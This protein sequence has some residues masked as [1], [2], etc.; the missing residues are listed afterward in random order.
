M[1]KTAEKTDKKARNERQESILLKTVVQT[2]KQQSAKLIT[3]SK[4]LI[5]RGKRLATGTKAQ[6]LDFLRI[7]LDVGLTFARMALQSQGSSAKRRRNRA[8][9][10]KAYDSFAAWEKRLRLTAVEKQKLGTKFK[11]LKSALVKLGETL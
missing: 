7:E 11:K 8:N 5:A 6:S 2:Q 1:R 4:E 3:G 9:A 10:R